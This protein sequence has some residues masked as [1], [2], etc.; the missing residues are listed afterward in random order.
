VH[1]DYATDV[2][3]TL[4]K[5]GLK[6]IDNFNPRDPSH[7]N[8]PKYLTLTTEERSTKMIEI[9]NAHL[10]RSLDRM[11]DTIRPAVARMFLNKSWISIDQY[12]AILNKPQSTPK[13]S[14]S[15]V[16]NDIDT[17]MTDTT[18]PPPASSQA[19]PP[20]PAGMG[21]PEEEQL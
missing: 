20:S 11:R 13:G 18:L 9:H 5:A 19:Q 15:V 21:K 17:D 12:Q 4:G 6:P 3:T 16:F 14:A 10:L 1:N 8:D 2:L 7:L